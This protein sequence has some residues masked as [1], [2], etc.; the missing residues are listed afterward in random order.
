MCII[1]TIA[2]LC[3]GCSSKDT[4][5]RGMYNYVQDDK[6]CVSSRECIYKRFHQ[7]DDNKNK[8]MNYDAYRKS[9][10]NRD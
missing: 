5:Y 1:V 8:K 9:I 10:E 4:F 2:V 6:F 3:S 7:N